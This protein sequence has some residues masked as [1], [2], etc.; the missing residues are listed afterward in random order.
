MFLIHK[1]KGI[2]LFI[3]DCNNEITISLS[4]KFASSHDT[5]MLGLLS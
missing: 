3:L 4:E 5:Y 2:N 1:T